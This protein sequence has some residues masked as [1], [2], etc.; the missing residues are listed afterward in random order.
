MNKEK[1]FPFVADIVFKDVSAVNIELNFGSD[2]DSVRFSG[3]AAVP[4]PISLWGLLYICVSI[5]CI[6]SQRLL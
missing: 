5:L 3:V 4:T 2:A 1:F 6:Y